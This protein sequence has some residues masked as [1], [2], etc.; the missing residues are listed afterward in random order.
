MHANVHEYYVN[1]ILLYCHAVS[2]WKFCGIPTFTTHAM[3]H[4]YEYVPFLSNSNHSPSFPLS[5]PH[6]LPPPSLF[7]PIGSTLAAIES[8][9]QQ[10]RS[11]MIIP[12]TTTERPRIRGRMTPYAYFV[13]ER[14]NYYR[15][16]GVPVQFTAFSKECSALWK[17]YTYTTTNIHSV[18]YEC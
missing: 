18:L 3:Q 15:Q 14:R 5:L 7:L 8:F 11:N 2:Q 1:N 4:V 6:S 10:E 12:S 17:V 13:Q 9:I 16:Q